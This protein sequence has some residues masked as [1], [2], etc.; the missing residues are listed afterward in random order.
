MHKR[1]N[2]FVLGILLVGTLLIWSLPAQAQGTTPPVQVP[3]STPDTIGTL[4]A[5]NATQQV[6]IEKLQ[7]EQEYQLRDMRWE[8]NQKL[9]IAAVIGIVATLLGIRELRIVIRK[10]LEKE[11][12]QLDPTMLTIRIR[13]REGMD[14]VYNRLDLSGLKNLKWY[15]DFGK[16]CLRGVTIVPIMNEEDED[17]FLKFIRNKKYEFSPKQAAFILYTS[18]YRV[19]KEKMQALMQAYDNLTFANTPTTAASAVLVVGRG[20]LS[21]I[22]PKET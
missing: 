5:D 12:Y 8:V 2:L 18:D 21:D 4:Q 20:L 19:P 6:Q 3:T 11:L 7:R 15:N 10:T 1:K 17:E 13:Q 9:F 14:A 16:A 22:S